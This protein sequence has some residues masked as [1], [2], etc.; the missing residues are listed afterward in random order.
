LTR[1]V[2][3]CRGEKKTEK[4]LIAHGA[5][6]GAAARGRAGKIRDR[7][8]EIRSAQIA[9]Q[10]G[11][12]KCKTRDGHCYSSIMGRRRRRQCSAAPPLRAATYRLQAS[13]IRE[14]IRVDFLSTNVRKKAITHRPGGPK[15]P[16]P[17]VQTS[18]TEK[19]RPK[20]WK[21]SNHSDADTKWGS[22]DNTNTCVALGPLMPVTT[23]RLGRGPSRSSVMRQQ[24]KGGGEK[25]KKEKDDGY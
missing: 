12:G 10:P 24:I 15:G 5:F 4:L 3:P 25:R 17:G 8:Q 23:T 6:H 21:E 22:G 7:K 1:G 9:C 13:Q 14:A 18:S 2:D 16:T 11:T 19:K 20:K